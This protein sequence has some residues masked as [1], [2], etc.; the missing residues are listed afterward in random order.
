MLGIIISL[1]WSAALQGAEKVSLNEF[2]MRSLQVHPIVRQSEATYIGTIKGLIANEA[3]KDWNM[4]LNYSYSHGLNPD[5]SAGFPID[6]DTHSL[7][8]RWAK[9]FPESGTRFEAGTGYTAL[10]A[11]QD[12]FPGSGIRNIYSFSIDAKVR[13]PLMRNAW[14]VADRYPLLV[15]D[16]LG[17]LS[18]LTYREDLEE[19]IVAL[20]N[21]YLNW[22]MAG[23]IRQLQEEQVEKARQQVELFERQRE[24]GVAEEIDLVQARQNLRLKQVQLADQKIAEATWT[25][26]ISTHLHGRPGEE[27]LPVEPEAGLPPIPTID[28]KQALHYLATSSNFEATLRTAEAM[29]EAEIAYRHNLTLPEL[30]LFGGA[31]L[32][33]F[34]T[35]QS[36]LW[37]NPV[38]I[39]SFMVGVDYRVPIENRAAQAAYDQAV[40][41]LNALRAEQLNARNLIRDQLQNAYIQINYLDE[42]IRDASQ[43]YKL[44]R[45]A[46]ELEMKRYEQGRLPSFALVLDAQDRALG[47]SIQLESLKIRRQLIRSQIAALLDLYL[48]A[49]AAT[50][51]ET[52]HE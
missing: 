39:P 50:L 32:G 35:S 17:S 28:I 41:E 47:A 24:R 20:V 51:P 40:Y 23:S 34:D 6:G 5:I 33:N 48:P 3:I 15:K 18:D 21:D 8:A 27:I 37:S 12:I 42:A 44:A 13:Q 2:L 11:K 10:S 31:S 7:S 49:Y 26:I 14:G 30:D 16:Y 52:A 43:L 25:R 38:E 22:K 36:A 46:S 45:Q 4:F 29:Q 19:L 9:I 1:I